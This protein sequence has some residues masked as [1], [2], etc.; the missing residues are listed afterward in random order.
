[1]H[2]LRAIRQDPAGFDRDLARRQLPARSAA[3]LQLD[4]ERRAALT[5][6]GEGQAQRNALAK[7]VAQGRR[8]GEDTAALEAEAA[9]LRDGMAELER[10]AEALD[11]AIRAELEV[12]PN[13]L[14]P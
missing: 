14:D 8:A 12:L 10:R 3:I 7:R 11:A 2:D 13:R 6:V 5:A 4:T 9:R 1:M